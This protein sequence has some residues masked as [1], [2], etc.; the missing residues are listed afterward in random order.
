MPPLAS[1]RANAC[2]APK[3]AL[4]LWSIVVGCALAVGCLG[5]TAGSAAPTRGGGAARAV[6]G[7]GAGPAREVLVDS[8]RHR[9]AAAAAVSSERERDI[10]M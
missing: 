10:D 6:R 8:H 3:R 9:Q 5:E 1:R 4:V 2:L 7:P